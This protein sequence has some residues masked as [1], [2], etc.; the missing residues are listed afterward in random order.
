MRHL[1]NRHMSL[2]QEDTVEE[3]GVGGEMFYKDKCVGVFK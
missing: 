2:R 1:T 3:E